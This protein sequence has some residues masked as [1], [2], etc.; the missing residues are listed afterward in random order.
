[1]NARSR[2]PNS[3]LPAGATILL[4][5]ASI[6]F[7]AGLVVA[8][9]WGGRQLA[10]TPAGTAAQAASLTRTRGEAVSLQTQVAQ[11]RS[12]ADQLQRLAAAARTAVP[13]AVGSHS[14]V[15]TFQLDRYSYAVFL[16]W[17]ESSGFLRNG[18]LLTTD[19]Y[20]HRGAKSFRISGLDNSGSIGFTARDGMVGFTFSGSVATDGTIT[21]SGLP[22]Y[23]FDGFVGGTSTQKLH[24]GSEHDYKAAVSSLPPSGA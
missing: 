17:D 4:L 10:S 21:V 19:N 7:V 16:A 18:R 13:Q 5:V 2:K 3:R 11:L 14:Y 1:M 12:R 20:R 8:N 15:A 23:V 6:S 22:W 24:P 9:Q